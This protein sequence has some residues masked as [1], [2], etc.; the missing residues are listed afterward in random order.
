MHSKKIKYFFMSAGK[1]VK[2]VKLEKRPLFFIKITID[3]FQLF[4]IS[5]KSSVSQF[6]K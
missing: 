5:Y 4:F 2:L 3:K 1:N 6:E